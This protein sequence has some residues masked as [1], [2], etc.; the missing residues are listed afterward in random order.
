[1]PKSRKDMTEE[2]VAKRRKSVSNN[3]RL[4]RIVMAKMKE[5]YPDDWNTIWAIESAKMG[6]IPKNYAQANGHKIYTLKTQLQRLK[7]QDEIL[8]KVYEG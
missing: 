5:K 6:I 2:Q 1:M 3:S 8:K 4:R 7:G